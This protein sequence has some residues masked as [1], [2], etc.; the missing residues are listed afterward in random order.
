MDVPLTRGSLKP[1]PFSLVNPHKLATMLKV[2]NARFA[3]QTDLKGYFHQF[4]LSPDQV[5]LCAGWGTL[6]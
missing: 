4:P 1:Q 5:F 6:V 2:S 3:Q